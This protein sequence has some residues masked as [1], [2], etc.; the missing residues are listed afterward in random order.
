MGLSSWVRQFPYKKILCHPTGGGR[1]GFSLAASILGAK[2]VKGLQGFI[3]QDASFYLI[4]IVGSV[5]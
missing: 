4:P 3:I 2:Q 5:S 1:V